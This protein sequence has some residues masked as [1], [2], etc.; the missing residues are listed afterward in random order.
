[1][2]NKQAA[3]LTV[4]DNGTAMTATIKM[5]PQMLIT[6]TTLTT[7]GKPAVA[8]PPETP[9]PMP[10]SQSF[11]GEAAHAPGKLWY[12]QMGAFEVQPE[13]PSAG[14]VGDAKQESSNI[15]ALSTVSGIA[16]SSS[17]PSS[18]VST[19]PASPNQVLR[20]VSPVW[21]ACWGYSCTG[22]TT[23]FG[24]DGAVSCTTGGGT[25]VSMRLRFESNTATRWS[26]G[27]GP[28]PSGGALT[29][30]ISTAGDWR[31]IYGTD[32]KPGAGMTGTIPG[33]VS[34]HK[35]HDVNLLYSTNWMAATFDGAVLANYTGGG[36]GSKWH[37]MMQMDAY[38]AA[39]IDDFT[40]QTMPIYK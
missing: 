21:P 17:S 10:W 3:P 37:L 20:Q 40:L 6:V 35:W 33:G 27:P 11:D 25:N 24:P 32:G 9:F 23:Y 39:A 5:Q 28:G 16:S 12:D 18:R 22:P 19:S 29:F 13:T 34:L 7:G 26:L 2:F 8:S 4:H 15:S 14:D 36:C 30:N 38:V 1:M 31:F